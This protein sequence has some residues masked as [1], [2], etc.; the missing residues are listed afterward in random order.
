MTCEGNSS[1]GAGVDRFGEG[2]VFVMALVDV[3]SITVGARAVAMD[4]SKEI[5]CKASEQLAMSTTHAED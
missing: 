3:Q 5:C 4:I 1:K 2:A